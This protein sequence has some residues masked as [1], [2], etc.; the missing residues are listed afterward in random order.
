MSWFVPKG[1]SRVVANLMVH[2]RV[3]ITLYFS[4]CLF[5]WQIS[6]KKIKFNSVSKGFLKGEKESRNYNNNMENS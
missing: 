6:Q 5:M 4:Y 2:Y 1:C 3:A